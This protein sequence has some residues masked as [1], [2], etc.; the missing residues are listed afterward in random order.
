M[1]F[2][3]INGAAHSSST[4]TDHGASLS[5]NASQ[6]QFLSMKEPFLDLSNSS[7]TF[8]MWIYP[9]SI[10]YASDNPLVGQCQSNTFGRCLHLVIRLGKV[11]FGF[12]GDDISSVQSLASSRWY[13]LAFI[14]DCNTRNQSI[15]IDGLL[16]NSRQAAACYLGEQGNLTIG[17][18]ELYSFTGNNYYGG[19][20]DQLS[21]I[22]RSKTAD[23]IL[24][25]ATLTAYFSFDNGSTTDQGP[26]NIDGSRR[27]STSYTVGRVGNALRIDNVPDSYFQVKGLVLLGRSNQSFS[28]SMWIQ[29]SIL[30]N[31]TIIHVS[32]N[33]SGLGWCIPVLVLTSSGQLRAMS[34]SGAAETISGP[35][36]P[37]NQWSH[38]AV[39]Y[40][41]DHGLRLYLNGSLYNSSLPFLYVASDTANYMFLGS[42]LGGTPYC[43]SS[44][45]FNGQYT[46]LLDELR[47]YSREITT[48]EV[49]DL[50][51]PW[52]HIAKRPM[53]SEIFAPIAYRI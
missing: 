7:W 36:I 1:N 29:P 41:P 51:N 39:T 24:C 37:L 35:I 38:T 43:G 31:S 6:S 9:R 19:L 23:E 14:F 5:L 22:G 42:S 33:S 18:S 44:I 34:W 50:A 52:L 45:K 46:G 10:S 15:Y 21:L 3:S 27:G 2:T 28:M 8:E 13:H 53:P 4:I 49:F 48:R 12:Y 26:L 30:R 40:S 11:Y 17:F 47:V 25:D 32:A 20:M 16:D